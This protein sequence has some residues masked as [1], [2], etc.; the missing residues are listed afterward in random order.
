MCWT[1]DI[2][3]TSTHRELAECSFCSRPKRQNNSILRN[4]GIDQIQCNAA[5]GPV[6]LDPGL[7][8]NDVYVKPAEVDAAMSFPA[9]AEQQITATFSVEENRVFDL[10]ELSGIAAY[11]SKIFSTSSSSHAILSY[12][13]TDCRNPSRWFK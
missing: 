12:P 4:S 11:P 3:L 9:V 10:L 1:V 5:L 2:S 13:L 7:V 6:A 8:F